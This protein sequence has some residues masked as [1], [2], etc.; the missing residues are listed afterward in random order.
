[1]TCEGHG[2]QRLTAP[3]EHAVAPTTRSHGLLWTLLRLGLLLLHLPACR[4]ACR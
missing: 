3:K 2:L 1:L 4:S